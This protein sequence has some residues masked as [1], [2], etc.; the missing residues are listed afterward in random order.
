MP[1]LSGYPTAVSNRRVS[2][3]PHTGP[4]VYVAL[5]T[6]PLAGG[7]TVNAVE[8]GLKRIDYMDGDLSDS[9]VFVVQTVAP[10]GN[11]S[12]NTK[13]APAPSFRLRWVVAATGVEVAGGVNLSAER[14]RLMAWGPL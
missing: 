6:G 9:G 7:D 5:T 12:N 13:S 4:A 11:P 14:V 10:V 3:F 2:I 8:A 1:P